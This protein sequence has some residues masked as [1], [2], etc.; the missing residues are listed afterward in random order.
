MDLSI[1]RQ[2]PSSHIYSAGST[3]RSPVTPIGPVIIRH[4]IL[5]PQLKFYSN[6]YLKLITFL[7]KLITYFLKLITPRGQQ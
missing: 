2:Q 7:P 6:I 1:L 3:Y 4:F 5:I